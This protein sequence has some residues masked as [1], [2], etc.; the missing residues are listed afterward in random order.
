[1]LAASCELPTLPDASRFPLPSQLKTLTLASAAVILSAAPLVAQ[2]SVYIED[3]TWPEV[4]QAIQSGKT[5]AIIYTGSTEQNGPHMAIGKHNFIARWVA[6]AIAIKLG[7]ALVYPTLPFAPTG[8]AVKRTAH[9]RFPGSVTLT[10][11]TYRAV[12]HDVA[13]SAID[14]GFHNVFI[15]GDH[16][17][18]QDILGA[19]AK[20]LDAQWKPKGV[21]VFYV[22]DLYFKEKQQAH[23]YEVSHGLPSHDVHAGTDDSS[24]LMALDPQHRWIRADKLTAS[25]GTQTA[26]SG[27]DGDPTT[28]TA[29]LGDVFLQYKVDDAVSEIRQLLNTGR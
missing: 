20:E 22:P 8:D 17:D 12:V 5:N 26:R 25:E 3:L 6:G 23:A 14:A 15:M 13:L 1:M 24:E 29:A 11:Q 28:A 4:R 7:D 27:V 19:V 18:G 9:M 16:G 2:R 21:R 10:A